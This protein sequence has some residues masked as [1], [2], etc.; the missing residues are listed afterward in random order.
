MTDPAP[1]NVLNDRGEVPVDLPAVGERLPEHFWWNRFHVDLATR[2]VRRERVQC[3]D[4]EDVLGGCARGFKLLEG[5]PV[6]DPYA[7]DAHL[8]MNLG[9]LSGTDFMTGLRTYFHAYSPLKSSLEGKPS[10]MW[11]AGS[12]KFGTK[13]RF[14]DVDEVVFTGR[15]ET[16]IYL[17]LS[18]DDDGGVSFDFE[19]AAELKGKWINDKIQT[20]YA[21]Y[22]DAHFAVLGPAGENYEKVRYAAIAL[23]TENQL[24][25]GDMKSRFCGRG[26]IGGV[27]GSKNLLAIVADT[28][29]QTRPKPPPVMKELNGEVARG[30]GSRR[31]RDKNRGNGGGGTWA[32]VEALHPVAAMPEMNFQPTGNAELSQ[33]M[34]RAAFEEGPYVV[35]DEACYRCGI[36]CHK[37]VYDE[38]EEG[39][40]GKFRAKLDYEPLNLLSS[41][42]GIFDQHECLELVELG[43]QLGM[44]SISLGTTLS[45]AMEYNRRRAENGNA[46]AG[47][48]AYGD[49]EA[50]AAAIRAI[51]EGRLEELGQGSKRLS[52]ATG[53]IAY[54]MHC[55]GMEFPAYLPQTNPG[56]PWALAGGHMSMRTYLLV[57]F[58]RETGMDYWVDAITGRGPMIMRDDLIGICKFAA[59]NDEQM[60]EAIVALTGLKLSVE[61]LRKTVMRTYLRGY[62]LERNQGFT[63]EDYVMP[64]DVH[65][66][67]DAIDLPYFNTPGF[68]QELSAKV[69]SRFD[70]MVAAEGV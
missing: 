38:N 10:A 68:F 23:S 63:R 14:L 24:K 47:G 6:D 69:C 36:R 49:Y 31:F 33:P 2:E 8:I 11:T 43:D 59:L 67:N 65:E 16:P 62:K 30:D 56:Y 29:D 20:L 21:K 9:V 7:P 48:L 42:L 55:K 61:D 37:N 44:D 53:D 1:S 26:G 28:K 4:L 57:V 40:A 51:G 41:N 22:P 66:K 25:S 60:V 45:Y 17:R 13:L 58:E 64:A 35:K 18:S 32:N 70:E 3:E 39:T 46:V 27:M 12:G 34:Y 5:H 19:D 50:A 52:E 15:S 54:A